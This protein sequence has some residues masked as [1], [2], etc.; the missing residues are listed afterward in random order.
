[1]DIIKVNATNSSN[2]FA[3]EYY[4][5]NPNCDPSC[6][7]VE[8]Q[9]KGRGQRGSGWYSKPGQN[10][11]FSIL[12]PEIRLESTRQFLLSAAV[13]VAIVEA[14]SSFNIPYLKVKWPNDIM[15][16]NFKIAGILIENILRN[17]QISA[18]VIG[19]GLN[20]NQTEFDGLPQ[21]ASLKMIIGNNFNT[22]EVL[23]K[24]LEK[25]SLKLKH[26]SLEDQAGI[27]EEYRQNLFRIDMVSTF[28]LPDETFITGIIRDVTSSGR[29]KVELEDEDFR[30]F[31]LKELKLMY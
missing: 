11:T 31:D 13:S 4:R 16:G 9:T 23:D 22:E 29:L 25:I 15:A 5:K 28:Q 18:S 19:V 3:R 14:L 20:V 6:I 27:L 7:V 24:I 17:N 21:A 1:M 2:D 26:I 10:L 12:Y 30:T 8:T